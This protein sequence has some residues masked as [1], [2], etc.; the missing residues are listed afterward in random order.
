MTGKLSV[1]VEGD[2]DSEPPSVRPSCNCAIT[3]TT[4]YLLPRKGGLSAQSS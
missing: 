4:T 3:N 2:G 1:W